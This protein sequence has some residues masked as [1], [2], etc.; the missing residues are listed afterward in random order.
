MQ[1]LRNSNITSHL[2]K[3]YLYTTSATVVATTILL[4]SGHQALAHHPNG[5]ATPD[6]LWSGFLSGIGHPVIN[7]NQFAFIILIGLASTGIRQG[8]LIPL[9]FILAVLV[10]TITQFMGFSLPASEIG[11]A[12]SILVFGSILIYRF[13]WLNRSATNMRVHIIKLIGLAI[14]SGIFHGAAYSETIIGSETSPAL[15]YLVGVSVIQLAIAVVALKIGNRIRQHA[16]GSVLL[17][18]LGICTTALGASLLGA[19][20]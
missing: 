18:Y 1:I 6:D 20:F 15:A 10:G 9:A 14:L 13:D 17:R 8:E 5:G 7:L 16:L 2:N 3:Q 19:T 11:I 4:S 12:L